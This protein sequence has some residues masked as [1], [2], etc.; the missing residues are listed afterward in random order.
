[1]VD[2][3]PAQAAPPDPP[4]VS[5]LNERPSKWTVGDEVKKKCQEHGAGVAFPSGNKIRH[6]VLELRF[7]EKLEE[8]VANGSTLNLHSFHREF[9]EK[10]MA[11]TEGDAHLMPTAKEK[12]TMTATPCPIV[13]D[14]AFPTS[15]QNHC[16]FFQGTVFYSEW[17]KGTAV[18]IYH[19]ILMKETVHAVKT[20]IFDWLKMKKLWMLAGELD[21]VKT[22]GIGWMLGAHPNLVFTHNIAACLNFLISCLPQEIFEEKVRLHG[23]PDNLEKLPLLFV[24]PRNQ[25][26]GAP[27]G[28]VVTKAVTV[29]CVINRTRLMKEL[30]AS[31]HQPDIPFTFILIGMATMDGPEVYRK[32]ICINN[33]RQNEV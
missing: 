32:F 21:S 1:M 20:K 3:P 16:Q 22:S 15:D 26:F 2:N 33:D 27:P 28:R 6:F 30:V 18:K 24:N 5:G 23:S 11:S 8:A 4:E 31:I 25:L 10:L 29:S 17:H 12:K 13:N 7:K 19:S 9:I 14:N